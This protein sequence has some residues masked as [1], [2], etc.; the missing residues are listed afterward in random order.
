MNIKIGIYFGRLGN[1]RI[2]VET[3]IEILCSG[4]IMHFSRDTCNRLSKSSRVRGNC[5]ITLCPRHHFSRPVPINPGHQSLIC[6]VHN[7]ITFF[8]HSVGGV[9][10]LPP[11]REH[12]TPSQHTRIL[13]RLIKHL[14]TKPVITSSFFHTFS[15]SVPPAV[16]MKGKHTFVCIL[17]SSRNMIEPGARYCSIEDHSPR[18]RFVKY[19]M[20]RIGSTNVSLNVVIKGL[21]VFRTSITR[22]Q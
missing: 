22:K 17:L 1:R 12:R 11:F 10:T 4:I 18:D 21:Q 13:H 14:R 2:N 15:I 8:S 6:H 19:Q 9:A 16:I 20:F 5:C 3:Q 7:R